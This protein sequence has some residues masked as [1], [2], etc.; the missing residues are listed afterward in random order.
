MSSETYTCEACGKTFPKGWSD[1][2]AAAEAEELFPG[3]NPGDPA[4]AGVVCDGCYQTIMARARAEAPELI[5]P[6]WRGEAREASDPIGD[7]LRA[8]AEAA[9]AEIRAGGLEC[10]SCGVNMADLPDGHMLVLVSSEEA[11]QP[12]VAECRDGAPAYLAA[13][14][15][16][17]SDAGFAAWQAVSNILVWD[18]FRRREAETFRAIVGE[19]PANFTGLLG[20]L[21]GEDPR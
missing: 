10:P 3:I 8:D 18:A 20:V 15:S 11:G 1:E 21:K 9:R 12:Q 17:M 7:A 19:G 2:E 16:P 4:E 14:S 5:G 13:I 6:G